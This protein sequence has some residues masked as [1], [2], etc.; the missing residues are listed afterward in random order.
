MAQYT[1]SL[2]QFKEIGLVNIL[3]AY[4]LCPN[5]N[6]RTMTKLALSHMV[7][8]LGEKDLPLLKLT[9]KEASCFCETLAT[10]TTSDEHTGKIFDIELSALD[11]LNAMLGLVAYPSNQE[12]MLRGDV[13]IVDFIAVLLATFREPEIKAAALLLWHLFTDPCIRMQILTSKSFIIDQIHELHLNPDE[14]IKRLSSCILEAAECTE[15]KGMI[16]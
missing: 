6:I 11:L 8:I 14:E 9:E 10:A 1:P 5:D 2:E 16:L 3:Q 13:N 4:V 7:P 12:L 15:M